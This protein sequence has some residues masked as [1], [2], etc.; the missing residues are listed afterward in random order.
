MAA[1][2]LVM[3]GAVA[4]T[5]TLRSKGEEESKEIDQ[6]SEEKIPEESKKGLAQKRVCIIGAGPSG[7]ATIRAFQTL[8]NEGIT[9]R[10]H[11]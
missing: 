1:A 11:R 5:T 2:A 7:L 10:I 9:S 3:L 4:V 8:E 6:E